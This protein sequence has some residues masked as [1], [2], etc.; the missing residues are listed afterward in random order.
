MRESEQSLSTSLCLRSQLCAACLRMA[1]VVE[2][3]RADLTHINTGFD[4]GLT[5]RRKRTKIKV[6][7]DH[8]QE[9]PV[10]S[11]SR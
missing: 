9:V 5:Q 4:D 3:N 1:S 6:R 10:G 7:F 8:L 11:L 2:N